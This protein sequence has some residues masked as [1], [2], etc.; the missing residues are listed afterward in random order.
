MA[1]DPNNLHGT[2][3]SQVPD[4]L[5]PSRRVESAR[6]RK[7]ATH[8]IPPVPLGWFDRAC[9]LPG[10]ALAVGLILWRLAKMQHTDTV[11]LTQAALKQ[12]GLGR[13]VKY[14]ALRS[15]ERAGLVSV[16]RR[17]RK[18]PEVTLLGARPAHERA[19]RQTATTGLAPER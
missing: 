2:N 3:W 6:D 1:H 14:D 13:W 5:I 4:S 17:D 12:H 9:V 18:S 8:F 11:T 7:K 16:R 15:L 10:K 19:A